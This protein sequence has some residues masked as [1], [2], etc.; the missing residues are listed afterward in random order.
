MPRNWNNDDEELD[1]EEALLDEDRSLYDENASLVNEGI[2]ARNE[3]KSLAEEFA[4]Q[5]PQDAV[6]MLRADHEKLGELFEQYDP[7]QDITLLQTLVEDVCW[8]IEMHSELEEEVFYPAVQAIADEDTAGL[9]D[10]SR[11]DHDEVAALIDKI[12]GA[13]AADPSMRSLFEQLIEVTSA[14]IE[15]E[16]NMLLPFAEENMADL[17][18]LGVAMAELRRQNVPVAP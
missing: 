12:R 6:Q 14:H 11:A 15:E 8:A 5:M 10:E 16:E 4:D 17:D 1:S 18:A 2:S 3:R 9:L 13:D 7:T